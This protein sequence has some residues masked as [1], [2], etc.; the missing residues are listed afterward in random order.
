MLLNSRTHRVAWDAVIVHKLEALQGVLQPWQEIAGSQVA[1]WGLC[2][3]TQLAHQAWPLPPHLPYTAA[4]SLPPL[5]TLLSPMNVWQAVR[6]ASATGRCAPLM[7]SGALPRS[8]HCCAH[9][10]AGMLEVRGA[11]IQ[12]AHCREGGVQ[13]RQGVMEKKD[14]GI[15]LS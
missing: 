4:Y 14:K 2:R 6:A 12:P 13:R 10:S 5:L 7:G 1:G 9:R 11:T 3:G 8:N 15:L